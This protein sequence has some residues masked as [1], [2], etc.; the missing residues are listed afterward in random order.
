MADE[1]KSF[2]IRVEDIEALAAYH[3]GIAQKLLE[4]R[5]QAWGEQSTL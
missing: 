5:D 2:L 1:M 3:K 4:Q